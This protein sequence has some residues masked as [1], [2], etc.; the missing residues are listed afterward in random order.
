MRLRSRSCVR[1]HAHACHCVGRVHIQKRGVESLSSDSTTVCAPLTFPPSPIVTSSLTG[2]MLT[3]ASSPFFSVRLVFYRPPAI[4][5]M[6]VLPPIEYNTMNTEPIQF[7][8][9]PVSYVARVHR[10]KY[11]F[12]IARSNERNHSSSVSHT[13]SISLS[14]LHS[15]TWGFNSFFC[16]EIFFVTSAANNDSNWF[17]RY[18]PSPLR[19]IRSRIALFYNDNTMTDTLIQ[20]WDIIQTDRLRGGGSWEDCLQGEMIWQVKRFPFR[21]DR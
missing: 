19:M 21:D 11:H 18:I 3:I 20:I 14:F 13:L 4:H 12:L 17:S 2:S 9:L 7:F 1:I 8:S 15:S 16:L 6:S 5:A 10:A